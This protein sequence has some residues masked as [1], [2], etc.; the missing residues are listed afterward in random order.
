M[1][2]QTQTAHNQKAYMQAVSTQI[3]HLN[4]LLCAT[5]AAEK[6]SLFLF[7]MVFQIELVFYLK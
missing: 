1:L 4:P 5:P 6:I 7:L 3:S 2:F